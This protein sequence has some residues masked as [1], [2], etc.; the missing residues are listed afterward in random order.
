[1]NCLNKNLRQNIVEGLDFAKSNM[2]KAVLLIGD[3]VCFPPESTI[4]ELTRGNHRLQP[5]IS[6][7]NSKIESFSA[8]VVSCFRGDVLS[9]GLELALAS[10]WRV[11]TQCS[12]FGSRDLD[13]GII[14]GE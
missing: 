11:A 7:V 1:M 4:L 12:R 8:P 14:P 3:E 2:A 9:W 13:I 10:H 6:E 5:T